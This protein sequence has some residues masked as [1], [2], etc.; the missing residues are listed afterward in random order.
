[1]NNVFSG[2]LIALPDAA[3][4]R[5]ASC[6]ELAKQLELT[7]VYHPRPGSDN[8]QKRGNLRNGIWCSASN[9]SLRMKGMK[10]LITLANGSR[11]RRAP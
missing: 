9:E 2:G 3:V 5:I 7:L 11:S 1:M 4:L 8:R 6:I 10:E